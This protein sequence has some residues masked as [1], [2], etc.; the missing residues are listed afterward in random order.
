M[1]K[2][3]GTSDVR[4]LKRGR[5]K[6]VFIKS[7]QKFFRYRITEKGWYMQDDNLSAQKLNSHQIN[8]IINENKS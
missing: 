4:K 2:A 1:S 7:L 5:L 8:K 3:R 6:V